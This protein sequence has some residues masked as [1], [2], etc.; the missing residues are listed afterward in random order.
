MNSQKVLITG[1]NS[2]IGL[3]ISNLFLDRGFQVYSASRKDREFPEHKNFHYLRL[4]LSD[5]DAV[6]EF[7]PRFIDEHGVPDILINNAGYGAFFEW[8][9]F[10][11]NQIIRQANVL[12][13][14]PSLL[15]RTFAPVMAKIKKGT[16]M[17]ITSLATLFPLPYMPLYNSSKTA[18]SALTSSLMLEYEKYPKF[19]DFRLGDVRTGFNRISLKQLLCSQPSRMKTAWSQIEKQLNESP[20]AQIVARQIFSAYKK[21]KVGIIYGGSFI[22]A[23]LAPF[24]YKILGQKGLSFLLHKRYFG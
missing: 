9:V 8:S 24:F 3:A 13:L 5:L 19:L 20:S 2:G 15:C 11:E 21:N 18:L 23:R 16:I 7:G 4:D 22:Q 10:E 12:F 1:G 17:N 14:A 6:K